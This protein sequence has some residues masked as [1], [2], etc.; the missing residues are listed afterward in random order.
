MVSISVKPPPK[1]SFLNILKNKVVK[2]FK[3]N[4]KHKLYGLNGKQKNYGYK[5]TKKIRKKND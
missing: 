5:E 4:N 3:V 1:F 2:R